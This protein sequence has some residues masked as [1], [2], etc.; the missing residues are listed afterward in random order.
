MTN[1][2][3]AMNDPAIKHGGFLQDLCGLGYCLEE[4]YV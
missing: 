4:Y 2:Y 3:K 1:L